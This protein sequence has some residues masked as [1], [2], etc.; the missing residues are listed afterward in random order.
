[1]NFSPTFGL[2]ATYGGIVSGNSSA[3]KGN[4]FRFNLRYTF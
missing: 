4:G 3:P 1:M 2:S